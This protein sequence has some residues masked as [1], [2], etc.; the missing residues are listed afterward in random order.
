MTRERRVAKQNKSRPSNSLEQQTTV[1]ADIEEP[2]SPPRAA[3]RRKVQ[4]IERSPAPISK[5][6]RSANTAVN[7][8]SQSESIEPH[9]LSSSEGPTTQRSSP[10]AEEAASF[11]EPES[12]IDSAASVYSK[13]DNI[14]PR[15]LLSSEGST[16]Q[17][18][19]SLAEEA[20]S[21]Q[22]LESEKE[23]LFQTLAFNALL[24]LLQNSAPQVGN[25][26]TIKEYQEK[27]FGTALRA[28]M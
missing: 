1:D 19:S 13:T 7:V 18:S 10:L 6:T 15:L 14:D 17:R 8:A 2:S 4:T 22:E 23:E 16:N 11:S 27:I 25:F 20:A 9:S 3:K 28:K 24:E 26:N 12:P 5:W 21:F